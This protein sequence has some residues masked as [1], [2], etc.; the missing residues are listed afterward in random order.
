M[1]GWERE[2]CSHWACQPLNRIHHPRPVVP[3]L[4]AL[5]IHD[6]P[7]PGWAEACTSTKVAVRPLDFHPA[8]PR[9]ALVV[10]GAK[11]ATLAVSSTHWIPGWEEKKHIKP[12]TMDHTCW[13][14]G[15]EQMQKILLFNV[16]WQKMPILKLSKIWK[17]ISGKI[18]KC[19]GSILCWLKQFFKV[20]IS[21]L[22]RQN[23][24][25]NTCLHFYIR[26]NYKVVKI[27]CMSRL[28]LKHACGYKLLKN[29]RIHQAVNTRL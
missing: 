20:S 22:R 1:R 5:V 23:K 28:K 11:N 18:F 17:Q 26:T 13:R 7:T 3:E 27:T 8:L 25:S 21:H 9:P 12:W 24:S 4:V 29:T 2:G 19:R 16:P 6:Q 10:E 15:E 14:A